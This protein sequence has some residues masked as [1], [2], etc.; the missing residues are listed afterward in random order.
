MTN[1][2]FLRAIERGD[3]TNAMVAATPGGIEAQEACGQRDMASNFKTLPKGMDREI[4]EGLGFKF[5]PEGGDDIFDAVDAPAGWSIRPTDHSMHSDI[6]D[7][8]GRVRGGIFYKAA[9]YDRR[10]DGRWSQRYQA[11]VQYDAEYNRTS[12]DAFDTATGTIL[13]AFPVPQD[14]RPAWERAEQPEK[15]AKDYLTEH[16]PDWNNAAAY[17]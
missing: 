9:F 16:F 13:Q 5:L 7:D 10:A 17:W 15:D 4:A 8:Q 11:K 12:V 3:L 14:D 6:V 1:P 2:A